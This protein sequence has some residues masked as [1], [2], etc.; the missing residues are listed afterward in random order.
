MHNIH[1]V[2]TIPLREG[3]IPGPSHQEREGIGSDH[4]PDHTPDHLIDQ[5]A[6]VE[7]GVI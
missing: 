7:A 5:E 3:I 1:L 2:Q 4:T 6:A